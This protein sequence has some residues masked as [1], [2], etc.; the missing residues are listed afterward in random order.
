MNII[1]RIIILT[2]WFNGI[3]GAIYKIKRNKTSLSCNLSDCTKFFLNIIYC[4][5]RCNCL[6]IKLKNGALV[7]GTGKEF[8]KIQTML[9]SLPRI[10]RGNIIYSRNIFGPTFTHVN[11][12]TLSDE[13]VFGLFSFN[14]CHEMCHIFDLLKEHSIIDMTTILTL[15]PIFVRI[16]STRSKNAPLTISTRVYSSIAPTLNSTKH[17]TVKFS[18]IIDI[19]TAII[20]CLTLKR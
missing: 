11:I 4:G 10:V 19:K 17:V 14:F 8:V 3:A 12:T 6:S 9:P 18:D 13:V 2:L 20:S 15:G 16:S 5:P 1:L 7:D